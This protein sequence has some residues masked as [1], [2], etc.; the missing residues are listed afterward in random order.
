MPGLLLL[1][2]LQEKG[3]EYPHSLA[4]LRSSPIGL[5]PPHRGQQTP[6][7]SQLTQGRQIPSSERRKWRSQF[8]GPSLPHV[9]LKA[10]AQTD[11]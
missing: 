3:R 10:E 2:Q 7:L 1:V 9:L 11:G 6:L 8:R 4:L 5:L